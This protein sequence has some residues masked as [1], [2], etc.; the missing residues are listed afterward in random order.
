MKDTTSKDETNLNFSFN[1]KDLS[2]TADDK[3]VYKFCIKNGLPD[4][5]GD[6]FFGVVYR[7]KDSED[8]EWAFKLFYEKGDTTKERYKKERAV[9]KQ[10]HKRFQ[11]LSGLIEPV[12]GTDKFKID[13][14]AAGK[15]LE[16]FFASQGI[17]ISQFGLVLPV[18]E[19][20]LKGLLEESCFNTNESGYKILETMNFVTR[21][22]TILPFLQ[23]I[24]AGLRKLY[25]ENYTHL[26]LKPANIFVKEID[27]IP[28]FEAV[29]ADLGFLDISDSKSD[30]LKSYPRALSDDLPLGTRHYRSPEQ[31]DY[32]DVCDVEVKVEGNGKLVRLLV[33]DP[34]FDDTIIEPGDWVRFSKA[35]KNIY[36][37]SQISLEGKNNEP[38]K[39]IS[40][41]KSIAGDLILPESN[42]QVILYKNQRL[43]T[44]LFGLGAIAYDMITCGKS[45]ERFYENIKGLDIDTDN[46]DEGIIYMLENY[47]RIA[48]SRSSEPFFHHIFKPFQ[49]QNKQEYAPVELVELILKCMLYKSKET[50]FHAFKRTIIEKEMQKTAADKEIKNNNDEEQIL[51]GVEAVLNKLIETKFSYAGKNPLILGKPSLAN[52]I[53]YTLDKTIR[54]VKTMKGS[55]HVRLFMGI[56]YLD[57]LI[58]MIYEKVFK[59]N[60]TQYFSELLPN[61]IR[62]KMDGNNPTHLNFDYSAYG[63]EK[64]YILNLEED[65]VHVKITGDNQNIYVPNEFVFMRRKIS[66][67]SWQEEKLNSTAPN[68]FKYDFTTPSFSG[69]LLQK[70]DWILFSKLSIKEESRRLW[71]VQFIDYDQRVIGLTSY[72]NESDS[73][74]VEDRKLIENDDDIIYY[75][76]LDRSAYYLYLLGIYIQQLFFVKIGITNSEQP[77]YIEHVRYYLRNEPTVNGNFFFC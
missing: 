60:S 21:T 16:E 26:D 8:K 32:F 23:T 29:V 17:V 6:G 24:V 52:S 68:L 64:E 37:I 44:D 13:K 14:Q 75:R 57:L 50:Y 30:S 10:L 40:F 20:T 12:A 7:I 70:N 31:K 28:G 56:K 66:L 45:P 67:K 34:K 35:P 9:A 73:L 43:R 69:D 22:A 55:Y 54:E 77:E 62:V 76:N 63:D 39:E 74:N 5:L 61:N 59:I 15:K 18:Y 48:K 53:D 4:K 65:S 71:R 41:E 49:H 11:N 58:N 72:N 25:S 38:F 47:K 3:R 33:H 51:I 19:K 46:R 42:T 1:S 27:P 36:Q 2:F